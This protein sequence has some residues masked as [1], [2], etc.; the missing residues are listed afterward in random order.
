MIRQ[1]T[2]FT[3]FI[4]SGFI[5][6]GMKVL[7]ATVG[8]GQDAEYI[9][10]KIGETGNFEG[11][12]LQNIAVEKTRERLSQCGLSNFTLIC[13][14]HSEIESLYATETFDMMVYN[15]GYLPMADKTITTTMLKT[16]MSLNAALH[17]IKVGG[18]ISV[19]VYPGHEEGQV[20][21]NWIQEWTRNL[22]PKTY[23]VMRLAYLN[24]S[25]GAPY[26]I[27]IERKK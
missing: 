18:I 11:I 22:N 21:S 24:Q 17:L 3:H 20:E 27:L 12:D 14:D 13:M 16:K 4:W 23:H 9:C 7:D 2:E 5:S 6:E 25:K 1:L 8:Q 15:L 10:R 26:L 19:T